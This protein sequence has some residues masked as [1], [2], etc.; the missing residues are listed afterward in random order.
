MDLEAGDR[1]RQKVRRI[2]RARILDGHPLRTGMYAVTVMAL[3]Y[4]F[5]T[6]AISLFFSYLHDVT[7]SLVFWSLPA[8]AILG[9]VLLV[10]ERLLGGLKIYMFSHMGKL[11]T[12][13][14]LFFAHIIG[15]LALFSVIVSSP[16]GYVMERLWGLPGTAG[17]YSLFSANIIIVL[18]VLSWL[19]NIRTEPCCCW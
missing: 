10:M 11:L 19:R 16:L 4:L 15:Y 2:S 9:Y 7:Y 6:A 12:A 5:I 18:A 17:Q 14:L 13:F 1:K 8:G 3:A